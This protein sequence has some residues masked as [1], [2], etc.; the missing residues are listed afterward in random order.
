MSDTSRIE[1]VVRDWLADSDS[2]RSAEPVVDAVLSG[3]SSLG[4][5]SAS[6][7]TIRLRPILNGLAAAAAI[8]LLVV[9]VAGPWRGSPPA[10]TGGSP[11][12]A[13]TPS[14]SWTSPSGT[15]VTT[16]PGVTTIDM[17]QET[18]ALTVD[19]QSVWVQVGEVGIGRIDRTTNRDTGIRVNEVPHMQLE[20]PD[21]WALDVGTGIVRLDPLSGAVL[22]TIPGI[23]GFYIVVDGATAWVTDVGTP[24][25]GSTSRP[26][27]SSRPSTSRP[28]PR[29]W[30]SSMALSGSPATAVA[31]SS[32]STSLPTRSSRHLRRIPSGN[33][34]SGEGA[35]WV[36][37]HDQQ[38]VRIDP[39]SNTVVARIDGISG[40]L[41]AGVAVGGGS[42]WVAVPQ[43]IGRIDPATNTIVDVIPLGEGGYVDLAWYDGELWA[44]S[45]DR[46]L[47]YRID[48][49]P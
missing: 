42:V 43:G 26:E 49:S 17:G 35:V 31:V 40:P 25:T 44:S 28:A 22:Q 47:V 13:P 10:G 6:G 24:S 9:A 8:V 15:S 16:V 33:L 3:I 1:R 19:D 7:P 48:P 20:G 46:N 12:R 36:W 18:W 34:A 5:D 32:G 27:R 30:P 4:Q 11:S 41:G 37:N 23:S 2:P 14:A 21:L 39:A 29:K 45:T 38:L